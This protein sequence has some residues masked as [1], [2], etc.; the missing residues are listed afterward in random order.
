MEGEESRTVAVGAGSLPPPFRSQRVHGEPLA[1]HTKPLVS[2]G[3]PGHGVPEDP[4]PCVL[5][6]SGTRCDQVSEKVPGG[7][8]VGG[9]GRSYAPEALGHARATRNTATDELRSSSASFR[10]VLECVVRHLH[11]SRALLLVAAALQPSKTRKPSPSVGQTVSGSGLG[12]PSADS[13]SGR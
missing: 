4:R 2:S 13:C 7:V 9:S 8:T 11:V 3:L 12:L 6:R 5:E 10:K 1:P